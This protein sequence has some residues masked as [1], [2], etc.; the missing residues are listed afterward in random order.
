MDWLSVLI[1]FAIAY[2]L[3]G[4]GFA[5]A[6]LRSEKIWQYGWCKWLFSGAICVVFWGVFITLG[7]LLG[8]LR[9]ASSDRPAVMCK[10][11]EL[12][13]C[14]DN[15]D[16]TGSAPP[17]AA[18]LKSA[19][20]IAEYLDRLQFPSPDRVLVSGNAGI[21]FEWNG[22]D[23]YMEMEFYSDGATELDVGAI[24]EQG[25]LTEQEWKE[26]IAAI[27]PYSGQSLSHPNPE[28]N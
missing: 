24:P 3:S 6:A 13:T 10:L 1:G 16:G 18:S 12:A 23:A 28:T 14:S 19:R 17:T 20:S 26:R 15:W 11:A 5:V 7:Y 2:T 4:V 22:P 21:I 25:T 8:H 27:H 9:S